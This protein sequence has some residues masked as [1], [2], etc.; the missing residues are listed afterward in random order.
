MHFCVFFDDAL[1]YI[2]THEASAG[3]LNFNLKAG[4]IRGA[5]DNIPVKI[6]P[7]LLKAACDATAFIYV[8]AVLE[9]KE[10]IINGLTGIRWMEPSCFYGGQGASSTCG[11]LTHSIHV[12]YR[13]M[14]SRT[15]ETHVQAV[16]AFAAAAQLSSNAGAT[17]GI[18]FTVVRKLLLPRA[19]NWYHHPNFRVC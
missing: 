14:Q 4:T 17:P 5:I 8:Q 13:A 12:S 6:T 19:P 7:E 9:S 16:L 11:K 10:Q 1:A 2:E 18:S 15:F 3:V